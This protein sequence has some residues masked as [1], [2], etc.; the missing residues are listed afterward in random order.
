[1]E[2]PNNR[3]SL[4]PLAS[5]NFRTLSVPVLAGVNVWS[6][7]YHKVLQQRKLWDHVG[8]RDDAELSLREMFKRFRQ[9]VTRSRMYKKESQVKDVLFFVK[10]KHFNNCENSTQ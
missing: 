10:E 7:A 2:E 5:I 4:Y 9:E 6:L 3:M 8:H 1:M